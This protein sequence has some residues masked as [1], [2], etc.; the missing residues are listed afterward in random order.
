[1]LGSALYLVP[2]RHSGVLYGIGMS[3]PATLAAAAAI[4][5]LLASAASL[6]PA[7][8]AAGVDPSAALREE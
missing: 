2:R 3:D 4:V 7:G 8:R 5:L 6:E 1:M